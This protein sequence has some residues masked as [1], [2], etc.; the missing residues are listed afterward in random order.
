MILRFSKSQVIVARLLLIV[1]LLESCHNSHI[2][3]P[4]SKKE[5]GSYILLPTIDPP[6]A[7]QKKEKYASVE[8]ASTQLQIASNI[9][10]EST[11]YGH[12]SMAQTIQSNHDANNTDNQSVSSQ[13]QTKVT[14]PVSNKQ[15]LRIKPRMLLEIRQKK[16]AKKRAVGKHTFIAEG[17]YVVT[18]RKED[19]KLNYYRLLA[20]SSLIP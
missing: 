10:S 9:T 3:L 15:P 2:T 11:N 8:V 20:D 6:T 14:I 17:G 7:L 19:G 18:F 12:T 1:F 13:Q 4:E 16:A 5:K